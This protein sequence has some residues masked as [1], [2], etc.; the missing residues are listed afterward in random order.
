MFLFLKLKLGAPNSWSMHTWQGKPYWFNE[1]TGQKQ[2]DPPATSSAP[3]PQQPPPQPQVEGGP[4][5]PYQRP[6]RGSGGGGFVQQQQQQQQGMISGGRRLVSAARGGRPP[7]NGTVSSAAV[8]VAIK[9]EVVVSALKS[10]DRRLDELQAAVD[11][12][13]RALSLERRLRAEAEDN[14]TTLV[15]ELS[16]SLKDVE[17][18]L[19]ELKQQ[20]AAEK[21]HAR[22]LESKVKSTLRDKIELRET[23][24]RLEA[25]KRRTDRLPQQLLMRFFGGLV[26]VSSFSP[27]ASQSSSAAS[28]VSSSKVPS[29]SSTTARGTGVIG[30]S[31]SVKQLNRTLSLMRENMTALL[32]SVSSKEEIIRDLALQITEYQEEAERR[33]G[34]LEAL[35]RSVSGV[36]QD[37]DRLLDVVDALS[38]NTIEMAVKIS[39]L[40]RFIQT[41]EYE[42]SA[43][44][45]SEPANKDVTGPEAVDGNAGGEDLQQPPEPESSDG[46]NPAVSPEVETMQQEEVL[47]Q[48]EGAESPVVVDE[49]QPPTEIVD[50]D[51]PDP[52]AIFMPPSE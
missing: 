29:R 12:M 33:K 43:A 47:D 34:S 30:S 45:E 5:R 42:S 24:A 4:P 18:D 7:G 13:E 27:S 19:F 52:E 3:G 46:T 25:D 22:E 6:S 15:D 44:L 37:R 16:Q 26:G 23:V 1:Q 41:R 8:P 2:W 14:S 49:P 51:D 36:L 28:S 21:Q 38:A 40:Q 39:I 50:L 32:E 48:N 17:D 20:L 35:R 9:K 11:E 31:S 10:A